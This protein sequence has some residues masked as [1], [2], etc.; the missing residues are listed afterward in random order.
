MVLLVAIAQVTP[1]PGD[2]ML[3]HLAGRLGIV[4]T[5]ALAGAADRMTGSPPAS[6]A[7][8][9]RKVEMTFDLRMMCFLCFLFV[10]RLEL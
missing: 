2:V 5:A 10:R 4:A 8:V 3:D 7:I 1:V 9:V 6:K